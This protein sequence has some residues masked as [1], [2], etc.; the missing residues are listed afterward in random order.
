M[1]Y[2]YSTKGEKGIF[3]AEIYVLY[4]SD[5]NSYLAGSISSNEGVTSIY[6][7]IFLG[8][9]W[10][11]SEIISAEILCKYN[12]CKFFFFAKAKREHTEHRKIVP[13]C[14]CLQEDTNFFFP[15]LFPRICEVQEVS[16]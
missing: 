14:Y 16:K 13:L 9:L 5:G 3:S 11:S 8:S 10:L 7:Y 1:K 15:F 12:F 6:S 2:I 4:D